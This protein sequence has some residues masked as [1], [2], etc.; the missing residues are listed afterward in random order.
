MTFTIISNI[1]AVISKI[2][3]NRSRIFQLT[4]EYKWLYFIELSKS[5]KRKLGL[6]T[7]RL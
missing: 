5:Y 3:F 6:L 2:A 4:R 1:M 7:R